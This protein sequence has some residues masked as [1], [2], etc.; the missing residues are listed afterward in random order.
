MEPFHSVL[1]DL[2]MKEIRVAHLRGDGELPDG[3]FGFVEL[4]CNEAN[5]DCRR[6][7]I[8]VMSPATGS[9]VWATI[10]YGWESLEFYEKWMQNKALAKEASGASIDTLNAQTPYSRAFLRL[11]Q[12][13]LEDELYVERLKRH[14]A[15]FKECIE[16]RREKNRLKRRLQ[17]KQ[18]RKR[19][20]R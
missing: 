10:N 19:K 1:P 15:L 20:K 17:R 7:V 13:V 11:F 12:W 14:Y 9:K 8:N 3:E 6:V 5:C 16:Q 4:Y 2:A 18:S